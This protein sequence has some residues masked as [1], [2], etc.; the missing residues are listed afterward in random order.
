MSDYKAIFSEKNLRAFEAFSSD[1]EAGPWRG[2]GRS[3]QKIW[4][5]MTDFEAFTRDLDQ[6]QSPSGGLGAEPLENF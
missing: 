6:R 3:P 5:K 1:L 4:T 2:S